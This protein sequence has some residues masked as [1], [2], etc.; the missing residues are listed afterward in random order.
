[1]G[2][3]Q[4]PN[5]RRVA[6]AASSSH[7]RA[8]ER[9]TSDLEPRHGGGTGPGLSGKVRGIAGGFSQVIECLATDA[10]LVAEG[11]ERAIPGLITAAMTASLSDDEVA[12]LVE[13]LLAQNYGVAR[14]IRP[15]C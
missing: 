9:L 13:L 12:A 7:W 10:E 15:S 5:E 8:S 4:S 6:G 2:V 14:R 1:M 11:V 3:R